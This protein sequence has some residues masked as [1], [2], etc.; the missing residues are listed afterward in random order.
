MHNNNNNNNNRPY[1]S[2]KSKVT[3]MSKHHTMI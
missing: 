3:S 1:G 2:T